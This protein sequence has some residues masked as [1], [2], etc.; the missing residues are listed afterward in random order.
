MKSY[1]KCSVC[2][3]VLCVTKID[4]NPDHH[5]HEGT[6]TTL[7]KPCTSCIDKADFVK[8]KFLE[9]FRNLKDDI[10]PGENNGI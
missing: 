2:G 8:R 10:T 9:I 4:A 3:S 6:V 5:N 1:Y 7:I